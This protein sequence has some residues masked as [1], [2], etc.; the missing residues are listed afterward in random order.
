[1]PN[2]FLN[3][4]SRELPNLV[5]A[6]YYGKELLG[7]YYLGYRVFSAPASI[8]SQSMYQIFF[9][10][11]NQDRI[12]NKKIFPLVLKLYKKMALIVV[13][14]AIL[15][16]LVSEVGFALIF[17]EEWREAGRILKF[18]IPWL[19]VMFVVS[20]SSNI[21]L[22]LN[23]Q[24]LLIIYEIALL[25]MRFSALYIGSIYFQDPA[26]TI[27]LYS[28]VGMSASFVLGSIILR[29]SW[30]RDKENTQIQD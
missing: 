11:A 28:L 21:V 3:S 16:M 15:A 27:G 17:G 20:P 9:Q 2:A 25:I 5:L 30:K 24:E 13:I 10:R 8:I 23:K 18:M 22:I 7:L 19:A 1:M 12:E 29:M 6:A 26:Y 4:L 14:P